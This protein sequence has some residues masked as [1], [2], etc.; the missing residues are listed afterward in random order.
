MTL[1]APFCI[2]S[3]VYKSCEREREARGLLRPGGTVKELIEL[4]KKEEPV[5]LGFLGTDGWCRGLTFDVGA[6]WAEPGT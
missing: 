5:E 1:L 6:E 4:L 2:L 3:C